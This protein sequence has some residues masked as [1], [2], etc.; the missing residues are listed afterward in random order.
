M[1]PE[2]VSENLSAYL[3]GELDAER[4]R[5][6]ERL[7]AVDGAMQREFA[8]LKAVDG[9]YRSLPR[10]AAPPTLVD[11][12]RGATSQQRKPAALL[13][14]R[15]KRA[16]YVSY[17][18]V[19]A[20]AAGLLIVTWAVVMV[21]GRYDSTYLAKSVHPDIEVGQRDEAARH[22]IEAPE[23]AEPA[24]EASPSAQ[25][26]FRTGA[27]LAPPPAAPPPAAN[28]PVQPM[29]SAPLPSADL[30][31]ASEVPDEPDAASDQIVAQP[32]PPAPDLA[33][34]EPFAGPQLGESAPG[35]GAAG[36]GGGGGMGQRARQADT[37]GFGAGVPGEAEL[38]VGGRHFRFAG[39][40]W[41]ERGYA[42]EAL[43]SVARGAEALAALI[44]EDASLAPLD[45]MRDSFVFQHAGTWYRLPPYESV[46]DRPD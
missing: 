42:G 16:W 40:V 28:M 23:R 25:A 32:A 10:V 26:E 31:A 15:R 41:T 30:D 11:A 39:G 45:Q 6:I 7:L 2:E 18:S 19:A 38:R 35:E 5:E 34:P 46:A 14:A 37:L 44:A 3:D 33:R 21:S 1:K 17:G 29:R 8:Q 36:L 24:A 13:A 12:V 27:E 43:E 22:L 4:R 20:A 9:L